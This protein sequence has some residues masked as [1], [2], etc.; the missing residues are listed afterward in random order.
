[1]IS[2]AKHYDILWDITSTCNYSCRHCGAYENELAGLFEDT[3]YRETCR[4]LDNLGGDRRVSIT[5]CGGEPFLR[6]DFVRI[7]DECCRRLNRPNLWTFTNGSMLRNKGLELIDRDVRLIVSLDGA[8][9]EENDN[10][11]G[12]GSFDCTCANLRWLV[13]H[14]D[15][16]KLREH[17]SVSYTITRLSGAPKAMLQFVGELG[18][19]RLVIAPLF[20]F[21]RALQND[22]V[23][24]NDHLAYFCERMLIESHSSPVDVSMPF[25]KPL[26][27]RYVNEKYGLRLPLSYSGCRAGSCEFVIRADGTVIPCRYLNTESIASA[28]LGCEAFNLKNTNLDHILRGQSFC[29]ISELKNPGTYPLYSPCS[30][31]EFAGSYCDPCWIGQYLGVR[32]ERALCAY[33]CSQMEVEQ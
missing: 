3:T 14:M 31:C 1:L 5:F 22:L 13:E 7:V 26:F 18:I 2:Q 24:S 19:H 9:S 23:P 33:S 6:E 11:R 8:T 20:P 15:S 12:A 25:L 32:S 28:K 29:K 16:S 4:I 21:G 30:S 10:I 27:I 17:A